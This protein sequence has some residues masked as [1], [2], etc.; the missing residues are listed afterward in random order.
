V[1]KQSGEVGDV[2][3]GSSPIRYATYH[4]LVSTLVML[5]CAAQAP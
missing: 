5:F 3:E 4:G 1:A 2:L